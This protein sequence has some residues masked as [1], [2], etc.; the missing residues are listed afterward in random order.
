MARATTYKRCPSYAHHKKGVAKRII[1]TVTEMARA[2]TIESPAPVLIWGEAVNTAVYLHQRSPNEGLKRKNDRNGY[3]ELYEMPHDMLHGFVKPT[4]DADSNMILYQGIL[5][6]LHWFGS[7]GSRLITEVQHR[8]IF[9]L[10]SKPHKIVCY[11]YDSEML[12]RLWDPK[13]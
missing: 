3:Q 9:G 1:R 5:N 12:W 2:I 8:G 10:I 11:T 7:Y 4:P 6:N 13:F